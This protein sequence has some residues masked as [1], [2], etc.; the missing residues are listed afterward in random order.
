MSEGEALDVFAFDDSL[1]ARNTDGL[2]EGRANGQIW[3]GKTFEDDR[4]AALGYRDDRHVLVVSGTRGGKGTGVVIPNLCL[5]PGSCIVIDPKGEN[6]TVTARRRGMGSEYTY[7][8]GQTVRILDPFGE[9][10]LDAKLKARYNPLDAIDPKSDLAV[11]DAGRIAAAIVVIENQHDPFWEQAARNLVKAL[12]LH[13]LTARMFEGRRNLVTVWRL[14]R[15]GDWLTVERARAAGQENIP[16]GFTLLWHGMRRSESYNGLIAGE[17]EQMLDMHERTRSG[18][19][20]VATTATEFIDGPPMQRLL[21]ASD[22]NLEALKTDPAGLTIYLTLPQR[23][24]TTHYRW[25]RLMI[26]LAVGEMERI[27]GRPA[28]RHP[29]LFVLDEFAGLRRMEAV[30]HA[31]AQ[32]AGFGVKFMFVLQNLPQLK[33]IYNDA[34]ETFIGNSGLRLF[35]QIDDNFTR[36]YLAQQLGERE[37]LRQSQSG[38]QSLSNSVTITEG[39][40]DSTTEGA[41]SSFTDGQ[42]TGSSITRTTGSNSGTSFSTTRGRSSGSSFQWRFDN[43]GGGPSFQNGSQRSQ[44]RSQS[45][46]RS[47]SRSASESQSLSSSRSVSESVS[48]TSGTSSSRS[49]SQSTSTTDGWGESVHKRLLLNPDE[50][51]RFLSRIDDREHPDYPGMVLAIIPGKQAFAVHRINYFEAPWF[52]GFFD[53]HP[54]HPPPPTLAQRIQMLAEALLA[55][56]PAPEPEPPPSAAVLP[57]PV[58]KPRR[59]GRWAFGGLTAAAISVVILIAAN[60]GGYQSASYS[61]G[62]L[63]PSPASGVSQP[64]AAAVQRPSS[65]STNSISQPM[66]PPNE[67]SGTPTAALAPQPGESQLRLLR[68]FTGCC[69]IAFS[70]DGRLLAADGA[71]KTIKLWD[72]ASGQ[73]LR[74]LDQDDTLSLAFSPDGRLLASG[75]MT[76]KP[77]KLWDPASGQLLRTLA[78][79]KA[80]AVLSLAFSPDGRLLASNSLEHNETIRLWDPGNGQVLRT[81]S[82]SGSKDLVV[83]LAFSPDGRLLVSG[84]GHHL[85]LWNPANGQLLNT[86]SDEQPRLVAFSPDGRLLASV[87]DDKLVVWEPARRQVL[88]TLSEHVSAFS[89]SPD[90]HLLAWGSKN[91]LIRLWDPRSGETLRTLSAHTGAIGSI[92]FSPDG[93]LLASAGSGEDKT[94]KLWD[95]SALVAASR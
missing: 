8:L 41:S 68:T 48:T 69:R 81:L 34:W 39:R 16:S 70:P 95:A 72:P 75:G 82:P 58:P 42:T 84:G 19:L 49:V 45:Q 80:I 7:G 71:D 54:D 57:F 43:S 88:R 87:D 4:P 23:Y 35:F 1:F 86:L 10:P 20:K 79:D 60:R 55:A 63:T 90:G 29:T 94:V 59:W 37:V 40:S 51:G 28:T 93:H 27:K 33:E 83:S 61:A 46:G 78:D 52:E 25:L 44:S 32:A 3:V 67:R 56:L 13:V 17:A 14:L 77:I 66:P 22:F 76:D 50:I 31:A 85:R 30:E 65:P 47:Q 2:W 36:S 89:F 11:D 5:W 9:V 26:S 24:M 18:I 53:P 74:T 91:G 21:E 12:I 6:A 64:S 73:V 62:A 15:Q 92:A 38:S